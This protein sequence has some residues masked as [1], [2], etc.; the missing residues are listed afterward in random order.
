MFNDIVG[1]VR[2]HPKVSWVSQISNLILNIQPSVKFNKKRPMGVY[3]LLN[4]TVRS[5]KH[6]CNVWQ[7]NVPNHPPNHIKCFRHPIYVSLVSQRPNL[8]PFCRKASCFRLNGDFETSAPNVLKMTLNTDRWKASQTCYK[9]R[10]LKFTP[11]CSTFSCFW[12]TGHFETSAP[13]E[14]KIAINTKRSKVPHIHVITTPGFQISLSFVPKISL[15]WD[16]GNVSFLRCP[17]C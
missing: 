3:D 17:Q 5:S 9:Y 15:F 13:N 1:I 10:V 14:A 7:T 2:R 11:F 8:S 6:H 16:I 12:V 4:N